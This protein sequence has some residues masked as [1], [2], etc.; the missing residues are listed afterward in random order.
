MLGGLEY[1]ADEDGLINIPFSNSPRRQKII[2]AH[3]GFTSFDEFNH[4]S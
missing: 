4:I 3:K 1:L 2:I